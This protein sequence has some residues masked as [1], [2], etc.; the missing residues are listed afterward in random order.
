LQTMQ[1]WSHHALKNYREEEL[2]GL[3]LLLSKDADE[4]DKDWLIKK[5]IE[6]INE[7]LLQIKN[8]Y[9]QPHKMR[10]LLKDVYYWLKMLPKDSISNTSLEKKLEKVL[11]DFGNW[12]NAEV[13]LSKARHFRKDSLPVSFGEYDSIKTFEKKTGERK[14]TLLK[15]LLHKIKR[16]VKEIPAPG[17]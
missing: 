1:T 4:T 16:H 2:N 9:R 10:K 15:D 13:L 17:K 14:E 11:D 12:Q 8:Y 6:I 7:Q 5:T 3:T